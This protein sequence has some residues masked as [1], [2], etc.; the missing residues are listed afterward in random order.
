MNHFGKVASLIP[1]EFPTFVSQQCFGAEPSL[2]SGGEVWT[3]NEAE[4]TQS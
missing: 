1:K 4:L 3:W 2:P